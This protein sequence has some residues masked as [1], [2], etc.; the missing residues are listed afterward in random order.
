MAWRGRLPWNQLPG[1]RLPGSARYE[2]RR[3]ITLI[4]IIVLILLV[5]RKRVQT[6]SG[7]S[8]GST[9]AG[10]CI[11]QLNWHSNARRHPSCMRRF[12]LSLGGVARYSQSYESGNYKKKPA[13]ARVELLQAG[14]RPFLSTPPTPPLFRFPWGTSRD[15]VMGDVINRVLVLGFW[16][17]TSQLRLIR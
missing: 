7:A 14:Y 10:M 9:G 11:C 5:L 12:I 4:V 3:V 2:H 6:S 1:T 13:R 17:G 16:R 15:C 8:M